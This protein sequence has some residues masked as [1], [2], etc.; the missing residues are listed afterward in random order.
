MRRLF[1]FA[2]PILAATI[3]PLAAR[4]ASITLNPSK[5]NTI[6]AESDTLSNG[7]GTRV[8]AGENGAGF[9]RRALVR[10]DLS[11]VPGNAVVDSV[12][13][14]LTV[15]QTHGFSVPVKLNRLLADWGESTSIGVGGGGGEGGGGKAKPGDATWLQ[16]FYLAPA[17][18]WTNPG[19]DFDATASATKNVLS[20][21]SYTWRSA[22]MNADVSFW[23][24]NPAQNFGWEVVGGET[25]FSSAKAFGSREN[26]T[27]GSRPVLTVYYTIP[28]GVGSSPALTRLLPVHP[29]PFNP[30]ASIRYELASTQR[31]S[32][33]VYDTAGQRVKTLI[34]GVMPA[35]AHETMWHGED[36]R[37]ARVASGVYVVRMVTASGAQ[38]TAKMVLLK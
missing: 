19:G 1:A 29:N 26:A 15:V 36:A 14:T 17:A 20:L 27:A 12:T 6:Y 8:F 2:L 35:G 23:L 5:D 3:L 11:S 28:T 16:R 37:G 33:I 18:L 32:L 30:L 31:V 9:P 10:F 22:N 21:G 4:S 24:A 34:D 13:L 25:T 7:A 38:A